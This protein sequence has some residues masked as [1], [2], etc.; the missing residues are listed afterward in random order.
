MREI[1]SAWI[2]CKGES[3]KRER[4]RFVATPFAYSIFNVQRVTCDGG[5]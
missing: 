2:V 5:L 3:K 4:N 1:V